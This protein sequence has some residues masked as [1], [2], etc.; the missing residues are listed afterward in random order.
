[1]P[2]QGHM[3]DERKSPTLLTTVQRS[4][5]FFSCSS[6]SSVAL[7]LSDASSLLERIRERGRERLSDQTRLG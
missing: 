4:L 6:S 7:L 1:M 2:H 5:I 3:A